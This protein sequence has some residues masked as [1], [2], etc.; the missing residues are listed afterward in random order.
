[1]TKMIV[2]LIAEQFEMS[3][4]LRS[5]LLKKISVYFE[6]TGILNEEIISFM[7]DSSNC[8]EPSIFAINKHPLKS[9]TVSVS[10]LLSKISTYTVRLQESS[11]FL[12]SREWDDNDC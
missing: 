9:I 12:L 2:P 4:S 6:Y 11:L 5:E 1:M 10:F 8:P 3:V 7:I